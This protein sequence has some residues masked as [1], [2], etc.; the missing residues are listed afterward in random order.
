MCENCDSVVPFNILTVH[1][2][3]HPGFFF[4]NFFFLD[5]PTQHFIVY[6]D[7]SRTIHLKAKFMGV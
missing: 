1:G 3:A 6:L 2:V 5:S 4:F 7:N